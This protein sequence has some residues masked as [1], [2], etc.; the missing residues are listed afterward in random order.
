MSDIYSVLRKAV[1][2]T[3]QTTSARKALY[4]KARQALN[5]GLQ[6]YD[7][8]LSKEAVERQILTLE[9]AIRKIEA[10]FAQAEASG[11]PSHDTPP[12]PE[13]G[14]E[15]KGEREGAERSPSA[16]DAKPKTRPRAGAK[17]DRKPTSSQLR[18]LSFAR[19]RKSLDRL[20]LPL[21]GILI[22]CVALIVYN[23]RDVIRDRLG[24]QSAR[25]DEAQPEVLEAE[26]AKDVD[27]VP[28][29]SD[30]DTRE[31]EV[32]EESPTRAE[33]D[34]GSCGTFQTDFAPPEFVSSSL[35]GVD[36][37]RITL[38]EELSALG[39][40]EASYWREVEGD[41]APEHLSGTVLWRLT[42]EEESDL[43]PYRAEAFI[44]LDSACLR[45][46]F[47]VQKSTKA[48][49]VVSHIAVVEI[50][51]TPR[52]GLGVV[53]IDDLMWLRD[54]Q[55]PLERLD[56]AYMRL[57]DMAMNVLILGLRTDDEARIVNEDL[58]ETFA[59]VHIFATLESGEPIVIVLERGE[60]G[61]K[62]VSTARNLWR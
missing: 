42:Y 51:S 14:D 5:D 57:D 38:L 26:P 4:T 46:R 49:D 31:S 17:P 41:E 22:L 62:V 7:P 10:E 52:G 55:A 13:S 23:Y 33:A 59:F 34:L 60:T 1:E 56:A 6:S 24:L 37:E 3:D 19:L 25:Q 2:S 28:P 15:A 29:L 47:S 58:L 44:Q 35:E 8:P 32:P 21:I 39:S 48:D 53:Q 43:S 61:A 9:S 27:A 50:E 18:W 36:P 12:L 45:G 40:Q 30:A 16:T 20:L 54:S 11:E